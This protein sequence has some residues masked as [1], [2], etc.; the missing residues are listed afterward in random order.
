VLVGFVVENQAQVK[1]KGELLPRPLYGV[2]IVIIVRPGSVLLVGGVNGYRKVS[3]L[4][5]H[6]TRFNEHGKLL[7][8]VY[9]TSNSRIQY[10]RLDRYWQHLSTRVCAMSILLNSIFHK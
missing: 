9:H 7:K 8:D 4:T 2:S 5:P 6:L 10:V 1:H 3:L